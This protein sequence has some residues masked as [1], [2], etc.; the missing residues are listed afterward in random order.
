MGAEMPN[1]ASA[2]KAGSAQY[3]DYVLF[4][5]AAIVHCISASS[6]ASFCLLALEHE[7]AETRGRAP[8]VRGGA[9]N[10]LPPEVS[11]MSIRK[12][13]KSST[14]RATEG[15]TN[16][17]LP[18]L[19]IMSICV[20]EYRYISPSPFWSILPSGLCGAAGGGGAPRLPSTILSRARPKKISP[21][22]AP[23]K[24]CFF[25]PRPPTQRVV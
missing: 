1:D 8:K 24:K 15:L 17:A 13:H 19:S 4:R 3:D 23:Q 16:A 25:V 21:K 10:E 7:S 12:A 2:Q 5:L 22:P 9:P 14:I 20:R 6:G 11:I 18:N